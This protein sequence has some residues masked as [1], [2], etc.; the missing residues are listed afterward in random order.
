VTMILLTRV[1]G[2]HPAGVKN[3]GTLSTAGAHSS[4]RAPPT[5]LISP[6]NPVHLACITFTRPERD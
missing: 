1:S 6:G 4:R 3:P 2:V 5:Y